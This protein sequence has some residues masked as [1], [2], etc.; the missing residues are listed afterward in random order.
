MLH[1]RK[2]NLLAWQVY[3]STS[4]NHTMALRAHSCLTPY[5]E[6]CMHLP[7]LLVLQL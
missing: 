2:Q 1:P 5:Y 3:A 6:G 7:L 4:L